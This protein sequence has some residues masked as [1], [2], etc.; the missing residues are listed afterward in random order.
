MQQ[1]VIIN[2]WTRLGILLVIAGITGATVLALYLTWTPVGELSVLG[3]QSRYL[4][5]ILPL[6]FLVFTNQNK[7]MEKVKD[8]LSTKAVL[9]IA[10]LFNICMILSTIF[11]YY[12]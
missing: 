6:V 12:N 5:G 4:I 2:W 9:N 3:V 11:K 8:F 10:L 1:K 7:Q